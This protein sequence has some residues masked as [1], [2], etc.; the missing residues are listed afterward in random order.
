MC[1]PWSSSIVMVLSSK[2]IL[3]NIYMYQLN[4]IRIELDYNQ[5]KLMPLKERARPG[6]EPGTSRTQSENHTPRPLSH[7][8]HVCQVEESFTTQLHSGSHQ[9]Y[10][11][12][13]E[14]LYSSVAERWSCKPKVMSSI[15]IGGRHFCL[16]L[17]LLSTRI[18]FSCTGQNIFLSL[19]R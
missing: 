18:G 1:F 5:S 8:W 6:F 9:I 7:A 4:M 11:C 15:L 17:Y 10:T 16:Y 2:I 12:I 3:K 14:S 19:W 13:H